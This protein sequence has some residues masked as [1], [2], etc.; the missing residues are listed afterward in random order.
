M[1]VRKFVLFLVHSDDYMPLYLPCF[2]QHADEKLLRR[3]FTESERALLM[4]IA[5]LQQRCTRNAKY[6]RLNEPVSKLSAWSAT[7]AV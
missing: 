6:L 7:P 1:V 3:P 4:Q 2:A 5:G